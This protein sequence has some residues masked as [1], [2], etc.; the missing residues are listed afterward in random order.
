M[1]G[2]ARAHDDV[3]QNVN[4]DQLTTPDEVTCDFDVGFGWTGVATR[5]IVHED[6]GGCA[7][8]YC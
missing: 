8:N 5:M 4:F 2:I 3:V 1:I 6:Y 7:G